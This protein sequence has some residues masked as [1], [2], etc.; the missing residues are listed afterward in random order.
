[1]QAS[2][3][4]ACA[5]AVVLL[6]GVAA[7]ARGQSILNVERLQSDT[8]MGAQLDFAGTGSVS[9]GNTRVA[10][11]SVSAGAAYR[12]ARHWVRLFAGAD[13]LQQRGGE[14]L[15]DNR[16]VHLRYSYFLTRRWRTF[17]FVQ[18][19]SNARLLLERRVLVG[20]GVRRRLAAGAGGRVD[21]G[22]GAMLEWERLD[23][24]RLAPGER[25][26]ERTTRLDGIVA[27]TLDL[28]PGVSATEV[29][30]FQPRLRAPAD[31]RVLSDAGL[32]VAVAHGV[33]VQLSL[34]WRRDSRPPADLRP[35]DA[36][37]LA[38]VT[39]SLR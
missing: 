6:L 19:Q 25:A 5:A 36:R 16:Y 3:T 10:Q 23:A 24:S 11:A 18:V 28:R 22:V 20:S 12:A 1:M 35:D 8:V 29:L 15:V 13:Y 17:H 32:D 38:G 14:R 4:A 7:G 21:A 27:G 31:Y 39:L 2:A 9:A 37:L 34:E 30:Y 33:G 26:R